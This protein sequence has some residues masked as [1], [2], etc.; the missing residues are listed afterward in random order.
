MEKLPGGGLSL[1]GALRGFLPR[2]HQGCGK[3]LPHDPGLLLR[4]R[5]RGK[6]GI[7][8]ERI[9]H[10]KGGLGKASISF[11]GLEKLQ[12]G[13]QRGGVGEEILLH[14]IPLPLEKDLQR[15][16][17]Q[18]SVGDHH[19]LPRRGEKGLQGLHQKGVELPK[20][21]L[22]N[23]VPRFGDLGEK[24][25]DAASKILRAPLQRNPSKGLGAHQKRPSP[26]G[27]EIV[28]KKGA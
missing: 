2:K 6:G 8:I 27:R 28:M 15:E 14:Q 13:D 12:R 26:A 18:S 1:Y 4:S 16:V 3:E 21:L 25:A 23:G 5:E 24:G 17:P 19:Q 10:E 7:R 11:P 22:G 9:P 20:L